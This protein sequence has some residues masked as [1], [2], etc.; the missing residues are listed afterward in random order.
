MTGSSG[1]LVSRF[2]A[3]WCA[4]LTLRLT[5][6][7]VP[8]LSPR[9][10]DE[11]GLTQTAL[12]AFTTLPV[13]LLAVGAPL[14]A[15]VISRT[16]PRLAVVVGLV[17]I[18]A[19]S[20]LRGV[21][22]VGVLFALTFVMGLAIAAIQPAMP[23]LVQTWVPQAAGRATATWVNGMLVGEV[24]AAALT[25]PVVLPLAGDS[26]RLALA[27]WSVPI[28]GVAV[29][30]GVIRGGRARPAAET[31][32]WMPDWRS[33]IVWRLG[34]L[35]GASSV[36]YFGVNAFLPSYLHQTG[37]PALV[38]AA[39][40]TLNVA[41]LP[42]TVLLAFLRTSVLTGRVFIATLGA[43]GAVGLA[44]M[45]SGGTTAV[46]VGSGVTG[47]AAGAGITVAFTLPVLFAGRGDAHRVSAG[48]I[49]I[50]YALAFLLPLLGGAIW[51][52]T[53]VPVLGFLPAFVSAAGIVVLGATMRRTA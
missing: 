5:V 43:I 3:L 53:G 10:Q 22:G 17:V 29:F 27:L 49:T 40:T 51:D 2:A 39:L 4:G 25:L 30:V 52:L 14:G 6:L 47:F 44:I 24:L 37:K 15:A 48:M 42:A 46:L 7:A 33:G 9:I 13:L 45:V 26:W 20:G 1:Y 21:A 16:G 12:A 34:L 23:D 32:G 8:P 38:G 41:Q 31:R 19:S 11:L 28:V 18:A 36:V 50:G 35:Q